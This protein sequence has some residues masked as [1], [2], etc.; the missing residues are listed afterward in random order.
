MRRLT[1]S[2]LRVSPRDVAKLGA[3]LISIQSSISTF[4]FPKS[5]EKSEHKTQR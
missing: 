2:T 3:A 4:H 1:V 5:L